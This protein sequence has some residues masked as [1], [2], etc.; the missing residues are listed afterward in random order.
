MD[1]LY[2][3]GVATLSLFN[4]S[5]LSGV[6]DEFWKT[7]KEFPEFLPNADTF[8]LGAFGALGNP[9]SFHNPFVRKTRLNVFHKVKKSLPKEFKDMKLQ[10]LE[11]VSER[12]EQNHR[13]NNGTEM[14]QNIYLRL[15]LYLVDG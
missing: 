15:M 12:R 11:C 5:E 10:I 13:K 9:S 14:W 4:N 3:N 6:R 1:Q 7:V 2:S 8:I